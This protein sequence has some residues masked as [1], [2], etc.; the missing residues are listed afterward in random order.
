MNI[1]I[2]SLGKKLIFWG[3]VLFLIGLLQGVL[4]PSFLN[5]RMALSAHLAAVQSGMALMIFGLI[6]G[7]LSL[8]EKWLR[9]SYYSSI[10]GMY[11][12]WLAITLVAV[13]G[14]SKTLPIAGKGFSSTPVG[15]VVVE[16]ILY[17]GS[18]L[19]VLSAA[20]IV[21]GLY[22]GLKNLGT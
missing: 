18:G 2:S 11:F 1:H 8:E 12:I 5:P 21:V 17:A 14:A 13:L 10:A 20:L 7:L 9:V 6:W 16:L 22:R 4:I 3:A 19:C 15:E